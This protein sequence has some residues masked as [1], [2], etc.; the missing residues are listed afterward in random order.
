MNNRRIYAACLSSYNAGKLIGAWID[1]AEVLDSEDLKARVQAAIKGEEWAIHDHEG[2]YGLL[3]GEYPDLE[4]LYETH[5]ELQQQEDTCVDENAI[6]AAI[7]LSDEYS[8]FTKI[9]NEY[10]GC[11]DKAGDYA[12]E[13][14]E[15]CGDLKGIPEFYRNHICW[16]SVERELEIGCDIY[17]HT[18]NGSRYIFGQW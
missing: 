7:A 4:K 12:Y 14:A 3:K 15:E 5:T 16:E 18:V 6:V 10:R 9:M 2:W 8:D 17:V 1:M 13:Q 11:F